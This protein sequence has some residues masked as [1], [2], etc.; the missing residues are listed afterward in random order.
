L[1]AGLCAACAGPSANV[2]SL[3]LGEIADE[4]R[5][6][7]IAQ[8]RDYF[9]Q[10]N[11]LNTVAYRIVTAN[12]DYCGKW[13]VAQTGMVAATPQSLPRKYQ[14]F[15]AE[16]LSL[17]WVRPTVIS[18]VED[19][20]AAK[21]G[22]VDKDELVSF[23][24]EPVPVTATFRWIN[25]FM[26]DNGERPITVI[27]RRDGEDRTLTLNPV[28]GCAIP[29]N[30]QIN[31]EAGAFTDFRQIV[32]QTGILRVTRNEA[33]LAILVGHELG[34]VTMGHY[35]KKN[36]N[37]L[38]GAVGGTVIDGG[39]LVG[40][41]YSGG[42][43]TNYLQEAGANAF[44][45]GFELEADY[46]GAYYAARAGY[47]ISSAPEVWRAMSLESPSMIRMTTTHPTSPVRFLQMKKVVE[48]IAGKKRRGVALLPE[49][50]AAQVR[51]EPEAAPESGSAN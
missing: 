34:H 14:K 3:T 30:L 8:L 38:I 21:A 18:V 15:S 44:S 28:I 9:S 45:P 10:L 2:P 36:L 7:E 23:N 31:Q 4:R 42:I 17:R 32:I 41:I 33:D 46:I 29:I 19:G 26:E 37:G 24:G 20:P 27:L 49:L 48:E 50:K 5:R 39:L 47:D 25:A 22:I 40:G 13:L 12:R 51:V 43:F 11:R 35:Q 1:L 6:E 16:A